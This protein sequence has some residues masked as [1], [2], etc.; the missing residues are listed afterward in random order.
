MNVP[1]ILIVEDDPV[2]R[3]L[4]KE[5][6]EGRGFQVI[7][8]ASGEEALEVIGREHPD[9][10][11]LDQRLPGISGFEVLQ[12]VRQN[13]PLI[14]V[15]MITAFGEIP[16]AVEAIKQGAF[17]YLTKPIDVQELESLIRRALEHYALIRENQVLK[18]TLASVTPETP[19]IYA[20]P[21]MQEVMSLVARVAPTDATVLITGETG[22]GK[23]LVARVIHHLSPRSANPWVAVNVAAL[24]ETL[25]ESELFGHEKGA[26]TGA[27]RARMGKFEAAH[28]GTLFLDEI[29]ELPASAQ[30]KLLRFLQER[31]IERLGSN[32]PIPL[33]VRVIAATNRDLESLV[34]EGKFREDLYYRLNV[35]RI[36]LPPLRERREDILPLAQHFLETFAKKHGKRVRAFTKEA[37]EA[38]LRYDYPGNVRE[39][40]NLIERAVV[41][42]RSEY[43]T[44]QDLFPVQGWTPEDASHGSLDERLEAFERQL[45]LDALKKAGG[46]QTK[47][48]ELLGLSERALRYRMQKL[49]LKPTRP[50][51][52]ENRSV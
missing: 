22:T 49:G 38:L 20:S 21:A 18:E 40:Q 8:A 33:D 41:L 35:I 39:L 9:L 30:V 50:L 46:V 44:V 42:S 12:W 24:P 27:D 5:S 45:I 26:F 23:E 2:Q 7:T 29:G 48:A 28:R 14:P 52:S 19:V 51:D 34:R 4:L 25:I 6:L 13:A 31:V 11:L 47:A 32:R 36:H 16:L 1:R 15:L 3:S 17:H 43:I 10:I 37:T